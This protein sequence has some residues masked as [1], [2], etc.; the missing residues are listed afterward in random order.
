ME[1]LALS[2]A[3]RLDALGGNFLEDSVD[4]GLIGGRGSGARPGGALGDVIADA[5][6]EA[7]QVRAFKELVLT[8]S[9]AD[10]MASTSEPSRAVLA[11]AIA[12]WS[13]SFLSAGI[14]SSFSETNF[15]VW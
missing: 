4:F 5:A 13:D 2:A 12:A 11:S 10:L 8:F 14:L 7:A 3:Q 6:P 1:C 15:S 9:T